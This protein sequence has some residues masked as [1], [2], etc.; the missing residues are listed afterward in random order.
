MR[1]N[2]MRTQWMDEEQLREYQRQRL[3]GILGHAARKVPYYRQMFSELGLQPEDIESQDD[4]CKL[5]RLSSAAVRQS[6]AVFHADDKARYGP[7]PART[8]GSSGFPLEYCFDRDSNALE[9]VHYWRHWGW[10]GYRLGQRFAELAAV[11]FLR[12]PRL[13]GRISEIQPLYGRQL[14][15]SMALTP[16]NVAEYAAAL[17]HFRPL[18]L[19]GLPSALYHLAT[20]LVAAK[21]EVIPLR[22][23]FSGGEKLTSEMRATIEGAFQCPLL[24]C[25]G[26]MERTACI[27]QCEEGTYHVLSDYGLLELV[28]RR[29]SGEHGIELALGVGTSLYNRAMPLIRYETGDLIE[30]FEDPPHCRCGRCFPVVRGVRGRASTAIVTPDGRMESALFALPSLVAGIAFLQFVQQ[31][32]DTVEVRVVRSESFN[33][34]SDLALRRMLREALGPSMVVQ[35][36]SVSLE[37]TYTEPSGKRPVVV[38]EILRGAAV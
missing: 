35:V 12:R 23:V 10:V 15:N 19:K 16:T 22:A 1:R 25:Y 34:T 31:R 4:I 9:F 7:K 5:P 2:L 38:S 14:L 30:V 6:S 36:H 17:M 33:D 13:D 24:D 3:R 26:H 27:A 8:S 20:L 11:H 32:L 21:K 28:D 29:P 37:E 18:Y